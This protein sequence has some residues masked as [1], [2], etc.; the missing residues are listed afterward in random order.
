LGD[1]NFR[2]LVLN[3]LVWTAKM[4]VPAGG[5]TSQVTADELKQNLDPKP[6]R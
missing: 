5:V 3:A 6:A 4:E 1:E 2:K